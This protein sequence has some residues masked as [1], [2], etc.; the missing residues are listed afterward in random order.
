MLRRDDEVGEL[1]IHCQLCERQPTGSKLCGCYAAAA[2][3]SICQDEDPT[4]AVDDAARLVEAVD[5][6]LQKSSVDVVPVSRRGQSRDLAVERKIKL[7]C[8]CH[9]PHND[10]QI[11]CSECGYWYHVDR[12]KTTSPQRNLLSVE[13]HVR[14]CSVRAT[15]KSTPAIMNASY[16]CVS[17]LSCAYMQWLMCLGWA[18]ETLRL[19]PRYADQLAVT[20]CI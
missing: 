13:F 5:T 2:A 7:H 19:L 8:S 17:Q 16:L 20:P 11:T 9:Q 14:C 18:L 10:R 15:L 3:M 1:T 4:G 12:I 6:Q